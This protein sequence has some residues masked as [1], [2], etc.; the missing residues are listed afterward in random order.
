[1]D[2]S[3]ATR[4]LGLR[5][6]RAAPRAGRSR[7][8]RLPRWYVASPALLWWGFFFFVPLAWIAYYSLGV[9]PDDLSQGAV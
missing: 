5:V 1:M 7:R 3:A 4:E 8:P 2:E 6:G 9:K